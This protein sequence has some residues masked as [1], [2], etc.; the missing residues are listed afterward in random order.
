M[1][2]K[3]QAPEVELRKLFWEAL[4]DS[5]FVMLGLVGVEDSRTRPMT[6]QVDRPHDGDKDNG[7][8]IYFFASKSEH[9]VEAM[10]QSH[11]AVAAYAP[12]GTSC[13]PTSMARSCST[14]TAR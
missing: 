11:R 1:F 7:G 4:D 12:R 8:P 14:R 3:E 6:A 2:G 10:G 9:L 5:P 13:S